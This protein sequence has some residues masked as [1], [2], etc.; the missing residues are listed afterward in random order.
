[1]KICYIDEAGCSGKLPG[2]TS[3]IQPALIIAGLI[4]DY[5]QLHAVTK[6]LMDLKRDM[7]PGRSLD[8]H[9]Y[10]SHILSEIKGSE[11]RKHA[12]ADGRNLRRHAMRFMHLCLKICEDADAKIV[13]RVWI[14]EI[15]TEIKGGSIYTSSIQAIAASFH[16]YLT[17][18][19][20][21]GIMIADSRV[22]NL[23][24][25]VAHSIF[26]QKFRGGRDSYDRIVELPAFGH[27]ENH[28]GI[29]LADLICSAIVTPMA[30]HSF[31]HGRLNNLH[32]RD[33]YDLIKS[34]F[35]S[36]VFALQHFF[37]EASGRQ[38]GGLVVSDGLG[39]KP[40]S[41]LF[42]E[43]ANDTGTR[44]TPSSLLL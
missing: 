42:H 8:Q 41:M 4:I 26:T 37:T 25:Q 39:H 33:G 34:R 14:K 35:A 17:R 40:S 44:G 24:V 13:G 29:Q 27:S 18:T 7:F 5:S 6:A 23:N 36:R 22:K 15:G 12:S 3:N 43:P 21:L 10:L 31:C 9:H 2:A 11:L 19:N 32:V 28:A 16:D 1:M 38:L 20:D 30:V